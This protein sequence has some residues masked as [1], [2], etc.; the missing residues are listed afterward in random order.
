MNQRGTSDTDEKV[1]LSNMRASVIRCLHTANRDEDQRRTSVFYTY[2]MHEEKNYK[3]MIDGGSCVNII[4]KTPINKM[5]LKTEPHPQ[6]YN[7]TWVD[8]M[9]QAIIQC[10]QVPINMSSYQD[11]V[12]CEVLDMGAADILLG[13]P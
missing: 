12:W 6:P 10:C 13:R 5:G 8:K 11:P 4:A 9:A 7:V 1:R 3:M 2:V